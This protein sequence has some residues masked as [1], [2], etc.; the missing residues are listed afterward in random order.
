MPVQRKR[1]SRPPRNSAET[2]KRILKAVGSLLARSGFRN[3]GI[4]A[5]AHEARVDKVLIYR[6]F[7]GLQQL[8]RAYAEEGSFWPTNEELMKAVADLGARTEAETAAALLI[9][10]SRALRRRPITQEIMRWELQERN[11]LTETLAD[12][13][14]KQARKLI[15]LFADRG[16]DVEAVAALIPAGLTY[17]T[18]RSKNV[19]FYSGLRLKEEGDWNRLE[20]LVSDLVSL[21]WERANR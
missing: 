3:I 6:Y 11:A 8:L 19:D 21:L 4:N 17:L 2:S 12:H 16:I 18:L 7:G 15:A 13:R 5:I 10:F 14:E 20:K 1:V 9:G